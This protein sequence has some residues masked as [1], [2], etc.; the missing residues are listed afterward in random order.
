M[1]PVISTSSNEILMLQSVYSRLISTDES[2][3]SNILATLLPKLLLKLSN[4]LDVRN[5]VMYVFIMN[6]Y[7]YKYI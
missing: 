6:M 4:T 5:Q 2:K 1:N 3:L 7:V